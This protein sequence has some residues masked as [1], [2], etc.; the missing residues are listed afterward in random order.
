MKLECVCFKKKKLAWS[1]P[2]NINCF[3]HESTVS[4]FNVVP[5]RAVTFRLVG[6]KKNSK[7][8]NNFQKYESSIAD[9]LLSVWRQETMEPPSMAPLA[10]SPTF[11]FNIFAIHFWVENV[12]FAPVFQLLCI[13]RVGLDLDI[14]LTLPLQLPQGKLRMS[15]T[16]QDSGDK[17]LSDEWDTS[18]KTELRVFTIF[19][20]FTVKTFTQDKLVYSLQIS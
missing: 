16:S 17:L 19:T 6:L 4:S 7:M 20:V 9:W 2:T 8:T 3:A 5:H 15:R 11:S 12:R 1:F 18:L 14:C 13:I 10:P